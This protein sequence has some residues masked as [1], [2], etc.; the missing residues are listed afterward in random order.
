[1][2]ET[3][4]AIVG[5]GLAGSVTAAMLGR[6]GIDAVVVDPRSVYPPDFRCEK[7]DGVQ[8]AIL[9]KTGL[10]DEVL[11]AATHDRECWIA[12]FGRSINVRVTSMA[13]FIR[14]WSTL[15]AASFRHVC[16]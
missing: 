8:V 13:S 6:A 15:C 10:A 3:D 14:R 16:I 5:A 7:L 2:R 11:R 9:R 12:R 1:M 4:V